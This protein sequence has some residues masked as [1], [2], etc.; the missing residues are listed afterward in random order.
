M[1]HLKIFPE[2]TPKQ[3]LQTGVLVVAICIALGLYLDNYWWFKI[4]LGA[5][6]L[7]LLLPWLFYPLAVA[8]FALGQ[9]L[10]SVSSVV[11][12]T[13]LFVVIVIP[14]ALLKQWFGKDALQ[15]KK[16]KKNNSSVFIDRNH[17]FTEFDIQYPF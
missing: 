17:T 7:C 13:L 14:V 16:F 3:V 15:L 11:L 6:L 10:S 2:V 8:W 1:V 9:A 12:L 5:A 4:A